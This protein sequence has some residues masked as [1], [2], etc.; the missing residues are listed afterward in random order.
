MKIIKPKILKLQTIKVK[1]G[2]IIKIV[3]KQ[4]KFFKGFGEIYITEIIDKYVKGWNSHK[5]FYCQVFLC[6][7]KVEIVLKKKIIAKG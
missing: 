2:N 5:R 6:K 3:N 1:K 7:G 4:N